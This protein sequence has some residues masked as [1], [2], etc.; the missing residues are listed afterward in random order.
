MKFKYGIRKNKSFKYISIFV[1]MLM[2]CSIVFD[3]MPF[4]V[5]DNK[6][7]SAANEFTDYQEITDIIWTRTK[8]VR[9]ES[10]ATF[11]ANN[12]FAYDGQGYSTNYWTDEGNNSYYLNK[13]PSD[14]NIEQAGIIWMPQ[15]FTGSTNKITLDYDT[16]IKLMNP[17]D[18]NVWDGKGDNPY[19]DKAVPPYQKS[20][21]QK[22][23]DAHG[24]VIPSDFPEFAT[25][26]Y[27][28]YGSDY[29][30][31]D[32]MRLF[33]GEFE[34]DPNE[35][36]NYDFYITSGDN[37][38]H[39]IPIDDTMIVL[40]DGEPTGINFTTSVQ[41]AGQ[42]LFLHNASKEDKVSGGM[43]ELKMRLTHNTRAENADVPVDC[44][45]EAHAKLSSFTDGL[46]VHLDEVVDGKVLGDISDII[47][48]N[49]SNQAS[50]GKYKHK[51]EVIAS[52]FQLAGG[53]TKL[54]IVKVP[55]PQTIVTKTAYD[56]NNNV[57]AKG[58]S[59]G[60]N[61]SYSSVKAGDVIKYEFTYKNLNDS[62]TLRNITFVDNTIGVNIPMTDSSN[63]TVKKY[64]NSGDLIKTGDGSILS[65]D[66]SPGEYVVV[67]GEKLQLTA[68]TNK[69]SIDN[70]VNTTA[71]YLTYNSSAQGTIEKDATVT[72]PILDPHPAIEATKTIISKDT[73][74]NPGD[75][76]EY[77]LQV[78]NTGDVELTKISLKDEKL[79]ITITKDGMTD[80]NGNSLPLD[81]L[82]LMKDGVEI[83]CSDLASL[84]PNE[85]ITAKDNKYLVE[86]VKES[87][88]ASNLSAVENTFVAS[89]TYGDDNYTDDGET[90]INVGDIKLIKE[91]YDESG[92]LIATSE[93]DSQG[94]K[95]VKEG[96]K[97][98]YKFKIKN[99]GSTILKN[100]VLSD[101]N[102]GVN[103]TKAENIKLNQ[104]N[105]GQ[106]IV[107]D[108][109]SINKV[110]SNIADYH[111]TNTAKVTGD[112]YDDSSNPIKDENNNVIKAQDTASVDVEIFNPQVEVNKVPYT[113]VDEL[114]ANLPEVGVK[115]VSAILGQKVYYKFMIKNTGTVDLRNISFTDSKLGISELS[116]SNPTSSSMVVKKYDKNKVEIEKLK[117]NEEKLASLK[118][119]ETIVVYD[120]GVMV[121]T[122]RDSKFENTVYG[123]GEY[124]YNEENQKVTDDDK[125][126]VVLSG[127][128][129]INVEKEAYVNQSMLVAS[130][131]LANSKEVAKGESVVYKIIVTNDG[132]ADLTNVVVNDETLN[133]VLSKDAVKINGTDA[134]L[135]DFIIKKN[136][137][138]SDLSAFNS[139]KVGE[140]IEIT[141]T[142]KLIHKNV[143]NNTTNKVVVT[144]EADGGIKVNDEAK[145]SYPV[146]SADIV[147]DKKAFNESGREVT[148]TYP[149]SVVKYN[150]YLE[151]SGAMDLNNITFNDD[152]LDAVINGTGIYLNG[153]VTPVVPMNLKINVYSSKDAFNNGETP[154]NT[155]S[156]VAFLNELQLKPNQVVEVSEGHLKLNVT[157]QIS[158]ANNHVIGTAS[159]WY[160]KEIT[161]DKEVIVPIKNPKIK[162]IKE[163]YDFDTNKL[164]QR[165]DSETGDNLLPSQNVKI[166]NKVYY[167]ITVKNIGDSALESIVIKDEKLGLTKNVTSLGIG[168]S[169][170]IKDKNN[171]KTVKVINATD[172]QNGKITNVATVDSK[173]PEGTSIP[174]EEVTV[175]VPVEAD[176]QIEVSKV[177]VL[178]SDKSN[179]DNI[180]DSVQ[181]ADPGVTIYYKFSITNIGKTDLT[182]INF[183]DSAINVVV[184]E[185]YG[186]GLTVKKYDANNDEI[187]D[188]TNNEKLASL[189]VG[190]TIV[191]YDI[192]SDSK[193]TH[194]TNNANNNRFKN[195]VIGS[196][197]YISNNQIKEVSDTDTVTVRT[198]VNGS[199]YVEKNAY[200]N[201]EQVSSSN[202]GVISEVSSGSNL[203]Y[204]IIVRNYGNSQLNNIIVNDSKLGLVIDSNT[205]TKWGEDV[206]GKVIIKKYKNNGSLSDVN[207]EGIQALTSLATDEYIVIEAIDDVLT[208]KNVVGG[209]V[210]KNLVDVSAVVDGDISQTPVTDESEVETPVVDAKLDIEKQIYDCRTNE[211]IASSDKSFKA[212]DEVY[213]GQEVY[214]T[215]K[216]TNVGEIGL[217]D[218]VL[219]DEV[220]D[221]L[222]ID[223]PNTI[224]SL[225]KGESVELNLGNTKNQKHIID[226]ADLVV[227]WISNTVKVTSFKDELGTEKTP[228]DI[229]AEVDVPVKDP[230]I[231]VEK[232]PYLSV[233]DL[234]KVKEGGETSVEV[235]LLQNIYY[236]FVV[237]ND[238]VASN[239]DLKN[240]V[241]KDDTLG[242]EI[243]KDTVSTFMKVK[244]YAGSISATNEIEKTRTNSEKLESLKLGEILVITD[245]SRMVKKITAEDV[246]NYDSNPSGSNLKYDAVKKAVYFP[247]TVTAKGTYTYSGQEHDTDIVKAKAEARAYLA[248]KIDVKKEAYVNNYNTQVDGAVA[249]ND[250]VLYKLTVTNNAKVDLKD[251]EVNDTTLN[252]TF[253]KDGVTKNGNAITSDTL[254]ITKNGVEVGLAGLEEL[255]VSDIIVITDTGLLIDS[256]VKGDVNNEVIASAIV[257]GSENKVEDRDEV[258][259]TVKKAEITPEKEALNEAGENITEAYPSQTVYYKLKIKNTGDMPL[260]NIIFE[261]SKL[262]V[263]ISKE[264]FKQNGVVVA[265]LNLKLTVYDKNDYVIKTYGEANN[266]S[267]FFNTLTLNS[268]DYVV[269][270]EDKYLSKVIKTTDKNADNDLTGKGYTWYDKEIKG[271]TK[272]NIPVKN[273]NMK[274]IKEAYDY[275]TDSLIKSSKNDNLGSKVA[276]VGDDI[277]YVFKVTNTGKTS[278]HHVVV[279]DS[280]LG[281]TITENEDSRL[282]EIPVN[283]TVKINVKSKA[284][285]VTEADILNGIKNVVTVKAKDPEGN[286]IPEKEAEVIVPVEKPEIDVEKTAYIIN[287]AGNEEA[288]TKA[289]KGQKVFYNFKL[290]NTGSAE[291]KD[292]VFTDDLIDSKTNIRKVKIEAGKVYVQ[293]AGVYTEVSNNLE[294]AKFDQNDVEIEVGSTNIQKL[295]SLNPGEYLVIKDTKNL[296]KV[297]TEEDEIAGEI[298]NLVIAKG[299]YGIDGNEKDLPNVDDT[300]TVPVE[301]EEIEVKKEAYVD[302][303]LVSSSENND[304]VKITVNKKIDYK[305]TLTNKGPEKLYDVVINDTKLGVKITK[306]GMWK[307]AKKVNSNISLIISKL[308]KNGNVIKVGKFQDINEMFSELNVQESLVVEDALYI[309]ETPDKAGDVEN[310]V[311]G[312]GKYANDLEI[313]KAATT[314]TKVSNANITID[315]TISSVTRDGKEIAVKK[316]MKFYA[317]DKVTF[318]FE[319]KNN[320][321]TDVDGLSLKDTLTNNFIS[322]V[323]E[324]T[325]FDAQGAI[326]DHTNFTVKAGQTINLSTSWTV[327]N[328][329]KSTTKNDVKLIRGDK[330]ID[331]DNEKLV[332]YPRVFLRVLCEQDKEQQFYVT[333]VGDDG[334]KTALYLN[335]KDGKIELDNLK[336]GINYKVTEIVPMNFKLDETNIKLGTDLYGNK[337]V[338]NNFE[339]SLITVEDEDLITLINEKLP[340]NEFRDGENGDDDDTDKGND[341][342]V[343][344]T[345]KFNK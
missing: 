287:K 141:S 89:G 124:V 292:I 217:K 255:K 280:K 129:K 337:K 275:D 316:G 83:S 92:N 284:V 91:A 262:G 175:E 261:D 239:T 138:I 23:K 1:A 282:S 304:T 151:N 246:A 286:D 153:S 131:K 227:G 223:Y 219:S 86:T 343:T 244:K 169:Y 75:K 158:D 193:I 183:K 122:T 328:K 34:L 233:S 99:L 13:I 62:R 116:S 146:K 39:I 41:G 104:L 76:I 17:T 320:G 135:S 139:L 96:T 257:K 87:G 166:G 201:G 297:I 50:N 296:Y 336:F 305:L 210:V 189:K 73:M 15:I 204:K 137:T 334:S 313:E 338:I 271:T 225:D 132:T 7:A 60:L 64:N 37:K 33:R 203:D 211:L 344:N 222:G 31:G 18:T 156:D 303:R 294:I 326:F 253:T 327:D 28:P 188:E 114:K 242:V 218:I 56:K 9:K 161:K 283:T 38:E 310:T 311:V 247:N 197:K 333:V 325:F 126:T 237:R 312:S 205:A 278:L 82:V 173:N 293:V 258:T 252:I 302:N 111:F 213:V 77:Q 265:P 240:I 317:G 298:K 202:T 102:L 65:E 206:S 168:K 27:C 332:V 109:Q 339:F 12:T 180:N 149:G 22:I 118:I 186:E 191:V 49:N 181:Y 291:V 178:S 29:H 53:M 243:T 251:I 93:D 309:T 110:M 307:D 67:S 6:V 20:R 330:T 54:N 103:L 273:P 264:G 45:S 78:K 324:W 165:S 272:I 231:S 25:W 80:K 269:A 147:V 10:G 35:A 14:F 5:F 101:L 290:T 19:A 226:T 277:Y 88:N 196:G 318:G 200:C 105:P 236:K 266:I 134:E 187:E 120:L 79:G 248:G 98:Y 341:N 232:Y 42:S 143:K 123:T 254:S 52:D 212:L 295:M 72:V 250:N 321:E 207:P 306:D 276:Y 322:S 30:H 259:V 285:T 279:E 234:Y 172:V 66:L 48:N 71:K 329:C 100:L 11:F 4:K 74:V 342:K 176:A 319:I 331:E 58:N 182:D 81:S 300:I 94:L 195:T 144:G 216:V 308:D 46:H 301:K 315:K 70:T 340:S 16:I 127:T 85:T 148:E 185:N 155:S 90:S 154:I 115:Q 208:D 125:A 69:T 224:P 198:I 159:T 323:N 112:N 40:V 174:T 335:Q 140:I 106:E 263:T 345:L 228:N 97:V 61:E 36:Q 274:I 68:P 220:L 221:N 209:T 21:I 171:A 177:G 229:K 119:N 270:S 288:I 194:I 26:Q 59:E 238:D 179:I 43:Y 2:L 249:I 117:T 167:A 245:T 214:Y 230:R 107:I 184:D 215:F 63:I 162:I 95:S 8:D 145:V 108:D 289:F 84:M 3:I 32:Q 170:T 314:V 241:I 199:I 160:N 190:E 113:T 267:E 299:K 55:K 256:N 163:V 24:G 51:I 157:E 128:A 47:H 136:N 57:I 281:I 150:L 164:I 44:Y 268:G 121:K 152:T 142:S 130:S 235:E 260:N 133:I 192:S